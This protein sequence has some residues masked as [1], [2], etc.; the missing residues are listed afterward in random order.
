M[1]FKSSFMI[2]TIDDLLIQYAFS[3]DK[4]ES[5]E[6]NDQAGKVF[7]VFS[8]WLE[9]HECDAKIPQILVLFD[10]QTKYVKAIKLYGF[11]LESVCVYVDQYG[12]FLWNDIIH[13]MT[14]FDSF[15]KTLTLLTA[16]AL[17]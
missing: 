10:T 6:R 9:W 12:N 15:P 17:F 16:A 1:I 3:Y 5:I 11:N 4:V 7:V 14:D 13:Y 8:E 2:K